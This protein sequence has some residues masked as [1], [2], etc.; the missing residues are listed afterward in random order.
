MSEQNDSGLKSIILYGI[1]FIS[2]ILLIPVVMWLVES[3]NWSHSPE[4]I[5]LED[6]LFRDISEWIIH[7]IESFQINSFIEFIGAGFFVFI[8]VLIV[9]GSYTLCLMIV[10]PWEKKESSNHALKT[11]PTEGEKD[12]E[13][14]KETK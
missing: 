13:L 7:F 4:A 8:F 12:W 9:T 2:V 1:A 11:K 10:K 6:K 3:L 14:Y 5:E